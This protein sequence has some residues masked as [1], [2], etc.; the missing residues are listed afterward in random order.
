MSGKSRKKSGNNQF[1]KNAP[2]L[3]KSINPKDIED[4]SHIDYPLFSFK[5]LQ[6]HSIKKCDNSK[7]FFD[8]LM[9]MKKLSDLGWKAIEI[10]NRHGFG[11]EKIPR[12]EIKPDIPQFVTPEVLLYTSLNSYQSYIIINCAH[13]HSGMIICKYSDNTSVYQIKRHYISYFPNKKI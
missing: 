8:Y 9:R 6:E 12:K 10:D 11:M 13:Y 2:Q 1:I 7:F 3:P 5:Y 4:M